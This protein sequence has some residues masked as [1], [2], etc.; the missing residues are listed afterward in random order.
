MKV[1]DLKGK[2]IEIIDY[3][4]ITDY[5][6]EEMV[7][8]LTIKVDGETLELEAHAF[9]IACLRLNEVVE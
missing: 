8:S 6:N 7:W 4:I 2:K 9:D 3:N 5:D 1:K